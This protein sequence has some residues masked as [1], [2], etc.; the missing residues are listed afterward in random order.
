MKALRPF[1]I[2][3][4]I[5]SSIVAVSAQ[6]NANMFTAK[7]GWT[8]TKSD[9]PGYELVM[10]LAEAS[11]D[12]TTIIN[13]EN[14]TADA[15]N[16]LYR[17]INDKDDVIFVYVIKDGDNYF[18]L[19]LSDDESISPE[20][21][22]LD[23]VNWIDSKG[24][25]EKLRA[26]QNFL[27][28]LSAHPVLDN[29]FITLLYMYE[30]EGGDLPPQFV[31]HHDWI[32]ELNYNF[33]CIMNA[34]TGELVC[35]KFD[36]TDVKDISLF[37]DISIFPQPANDKLNVL[38]PSGINTTS[39]EIYNFLGEKIY[40]NNISSS[41]L[42][43]NISLANFAAGTYILKINTSNQALIRKFSIVK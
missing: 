25:I 14:G 8:N 35:H 15:W 11:M 31:N 33:Q 20:V 19:L 17:N 13:L 41:S 26:N 9:Y 40:A 10:I 36:D 39:I 27:D 12:S 5:C 7:D 32:I 1:L 30:D 23:D 16:Y 22:K 18:P 3:F 6:D 2:L 28:Y 38:L 29:I 34:L 37:D 43:I 24:F 21:K 4:I 42:M